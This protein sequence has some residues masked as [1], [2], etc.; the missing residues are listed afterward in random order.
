MSN[1]LAEFIEGLFFGRERQGIRSAA[2]RR[3]SGRRA[4]REFPLRRSPL[5][6]LWMC[7][8]SVSPGSPRAG[9]T[10]VS[11]YAHSPFHALARMN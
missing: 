3:F 10:L 5:A 6:V 2:L 1:F 9:A 4:H 11:A 7:G 8:P